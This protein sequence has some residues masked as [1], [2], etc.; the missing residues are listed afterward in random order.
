MVLIVFSKADAAVKSGH[1]QDMEYRTQEW[2]RIPGKQAVQAVCG[3]EELW[4]E[5]V[6]Y[7]TWKGITSVHV[8]TCQTYSGRKRQKNAYSYPFHICQFV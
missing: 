5:V 7:Q 2:S 3:D 6:R 4:G 8:L 1:R